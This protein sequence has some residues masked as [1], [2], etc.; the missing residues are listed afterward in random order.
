M[1]DDSSPYDHDIL[2]VQVDELSGPYLLVATAQLAQ[3]QVLFDGNA[4]R[5]T[6]KPLD[7]GV[8]KFSFADVRAQQVQ[9]L[10][11]GMH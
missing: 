8:S 3:I 9:A 4:I 10:L 2:K 6:V 11:D 5:Y 7:S 1:R